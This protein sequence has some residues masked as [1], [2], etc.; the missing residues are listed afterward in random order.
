MAYTHLVPSERHKIQTLSEEGYPQEEIARRIGK[1]QSVVSREL[2]RNKEGALSYDAARAMKLAKTRRSDARHAARKFVKDPALWSS[3]VRRLK[4]KDSPEQIAGVWKRKGGAAVT[5]DTIYRFLYDDHPELRG[6]LR[7]K[8]GRWRRKHGT[9]LREKRREEAKKRRIDVRP[10]EIELRREI[11]HWEGDTVR[12]KEKIQGIA[13]HVERTAGY[14]IGIKLDHVTAHLL[15]EA[16]VAYFKKIPKK[17]KISETFDNG[18]EFA[19]Y[20]LIEK[21]TGMTV[22][23]AHP[24]HS[25]E[26]GTNENWNGLLREFFPKGS[27]FATVSQK[28]VDRAVRNLNHRP[29]KRLGYLT[30]HEVFV[31]GM[32]P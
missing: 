10:P 23:F 15:R 4:K 6:Y 26:R 16:S 5:H 30:P 3:V 24:Y 21:G 25:W 14:G 17:K 28:D 8:K 22:Y 7:S 1:D 27:K 32:I 29:R 20:E 19:E 31:K 13:T 11:G 9:K 18:T 2:R 12:G